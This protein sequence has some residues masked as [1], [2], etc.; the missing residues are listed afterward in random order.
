MRTLAIALVS[1][2]AGA[3]AVAPSDLLV[4]EDVPDGFEL[5]VEPPSV[6]TF[7]EYAE[8]SPEAIA[9]VDPAGEAAQGMRAAVDVWASQG[10][11]ILLREVTRWATEEDAGG[12]VEQAIVVGVQNGLDRNDPPFDGA[13]A[14][15][16]ADEG[17]FAMSVAHFAVFE[18]SDAVID[19]AVTALAER[20]RSQTGQD[21]APAPDDGESATAGDDGSSGGIGIGTVVLWIAV[22]GGVTW[23]IMRL[24]RRADGDGRRPDRQGRNNRPG[25]DDPGDTDVDDVIE[26]AR[27]RSRAEREIEAVPDP[28]DPGWT[29]P[30]D[31]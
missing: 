13:V 29:P 15:L 12:F 19:E 8:L 17:R 20:V 9:H 25:R 4:A 23:L 11:D 28:T 14:F 22:I 5:V 27:A 3:S 7:D 16:G 31:Y 1:L 2:A 26:R 30:D 24:R 6:L 21:V 18:G 10:D